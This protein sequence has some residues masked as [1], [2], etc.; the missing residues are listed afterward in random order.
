MQKHKIVLVSIVNLPL[1]ISHMMLEEFTQGSM[2][3]P[4]SLDPLSDQLDGG[5]QTVG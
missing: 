4:S 1:S 3:I 5:G 2:V